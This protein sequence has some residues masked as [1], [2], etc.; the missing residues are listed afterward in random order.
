METSQTNK[1]A[2]R[3]RSPAIAGSPTNNQERQRHSIAA[4][5][6]LTRSSAATLGLLPKIQEPCKR[7]NPF[8]SAG[9]LQRAAFESLWFQ[10]SCG[11]SLVFK[12]RLMFRLSKRFVICIRDHVPIFIAAKKIEIVWSHLANCESR[13]R[14]HHFAANNLLRLFCEAMPLINRRIKDNL[15]ST[16]KF[17]CRFHNL[18]STLSILS[19]SKT[20][21]LFSRA[22]QCS[23]ASSF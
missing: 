21:G 17:R 16:H 22:R 18:P 1:N 14:A 5:Q 3:Q 9:R 4:A 7:F 20:W 11:N 12:F 23:N 19:I 8:L 15:H 6:A 13:H 10:P 2:E